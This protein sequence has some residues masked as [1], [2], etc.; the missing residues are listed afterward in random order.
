MNCPS[1]AFNKE[2]ENFYDKQVINIY[3]ICLDYW[4][5]FPMGISFSCFLGFTADIKL[6]PVQKYR[7]QCIFIRKIVKVLVKEGS[8]KAHDQIQCNG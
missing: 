2:F 8:M 6:K 3:I 1:S 7:L 5:I 4:R